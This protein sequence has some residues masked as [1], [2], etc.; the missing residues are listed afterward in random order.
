[1]RK[2]T[3]DVPVLAVNNKIDLSNWCSVGLVELRKYE[4]IAASGGNYSYLLLKFVG[5][6]HEA[7]DEPL[8]DSPPY[9]DK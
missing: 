5:L 4:G 9:F 3:P 7:G 8:P 6:R 2:G 1:M